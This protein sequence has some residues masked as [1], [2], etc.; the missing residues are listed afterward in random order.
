[1]ANPEAAVCASLAP[2]ADAGTEFK[3]RHDPFQQRAREV[4]F[5]HWDRSFLSKLVCQGN[6]KDEWKGSTDRYYAAIKASDISLERVSEV[7]RRAGL[8]DHYVVR[9]LRRFHELFS[10]LDIHLKHLPS[11][12]VILELGTALH[13]T[14][15][16]REFLRCQYDTI[17]RPVHIGGP[18]PEWATRLGSRV[19]WQIDLDLLQQYS[20][21]LSEIPSSGYDAI[22][23]CEVVEHLK[24]APRDIIGLVSRD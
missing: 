3:P 10:Y 22:V 14:G 24:R 17:C 18:P 13:T 11:E 9:H 23:C 20:E 21:N 15:F 8:A 2:E 19:H 7:Y 16:Y 4:L 5:R 6:F 1:M 12:P